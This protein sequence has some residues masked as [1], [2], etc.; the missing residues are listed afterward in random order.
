MLQHQLRLMIPEGLTLDDGAWRN[1]QNEEPRGKHDGEEQEPEMS[2][3]SGREM[4]SR[5]KTSRRREIPT[6]VFL[7]QRNGASSYLSGDV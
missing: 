3:E 1:Q 4:G 7:L 5:Q 6:L 2:L